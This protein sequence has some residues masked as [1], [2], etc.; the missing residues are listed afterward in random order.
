MKTFA[1]AA[2]AAIISALAV[3]PSALADDIYTFSD[4]G[5]TYYAQPEPMVLE[6]RAR[7][8]TQPQFIERTL[9]QPVVVQREMPVVLEDTQPVIFADIECSLPRS[10]RQVV[11]RR[12]DWIRRSSM[13][14]CSKQLRLISPRHFQ[15]AA[16]AG[17]PSR[18]SLLV[19]FGSRQ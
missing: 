4:S 10:L 14:T 7:T 13:S 19:C 5:T 1:M 18:A 3:I 9:T 12:S 11:L 6:H 8:T 15:I 2:S 17:A 16:K